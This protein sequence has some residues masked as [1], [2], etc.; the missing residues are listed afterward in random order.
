MDA[1]LVRAARAGIEVLLKLKGS[2]IV[3]VPAKGT[4]VEQPGGGYDYLPATP[5]AAQRFSIADVTGRTSSQTVTESGLA[6]NQ[7]QLSMTGRYNSLAEIGDE[8]QDSEARYR[9]DELIVDN[10]Y[11]KQWIVM[12]IGQGSNYG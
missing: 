3:L 8:W 12:Q 11:K 4:K 1:G 2:D 5:R 10:E 9:V 6:T 7:R